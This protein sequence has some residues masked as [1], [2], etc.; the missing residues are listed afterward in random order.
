MG[1][2]SPLMTSMRGLDV[3]SSIKKIQCISDVSI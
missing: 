2:L 1:E 3:V